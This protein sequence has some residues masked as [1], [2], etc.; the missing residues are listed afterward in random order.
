MKDYVCGQSW[1]EVGERDEETARRGICII[2]EKD[3]FAQVAAVRGN[4]NGK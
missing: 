4:N 2:L 1:E 3:K